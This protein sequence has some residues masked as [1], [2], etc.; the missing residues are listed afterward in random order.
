MFFQIFYEFQKILQKKYLILFLITICIINLGTFIY[1]QQLNPMFPT[2]AYLKLQTQ[3]NKIPNHQRY[4]YIYEEYQ[5]YHAFQIIENIEQLKKNSQENQNIITLLQNENP[6]I[7]TKYQKLYQENHQTY[8]THSIESEAAFLEKIYNEFYIL[9]QYPMYLQEIQEKANTITQIGIFQKNNDFSQKNIEKTAQDYQ[10]L[11]HVNILYENE[12][13][14]QDALSFPITNLLIMISMFVLA[15]SMV[16]DEKEKK[17]FSIIKMTINGQW[18]LMLFKCV[19][20]MFIVGI[21]MFIMLLSQL[22]YMNMTVGIGHLSKSIQSL[23]S[24]SYCPFAINVWQ[25]LWLFFLMKWIAISF[26]GLLMMWFLIVMKHKILALLI[27][28]ILVGIEFVLYIFIPPL[29][30]LYLLKYLNIVSFLQIQTLFQIYRNINIL[31]EAV[32][33]QWLMF[34][35][36]MIGFIFIFIMCI[37]TYHYKK[38]MLVSIFEFPFSFKRHKISSSLLVQ[39]FYKTF[40]IQ[41]ALVLCVVCIGLQIYQYHDIT[42][43]RNQEEIIYMEYMKKLEGKL[44]PEKEQ[45]ILQQKQYYES[46]HQQQELIMQKKENKEI[47]SQKANQ[48][49]D[50]INQNLEGE[51]IFDNVLE[52]YQRVTHNSNCEF[53]V[54]YAYQNVFLQNTWTLIPTIVLCIFIIISGSQMFPYEYQNM[55]NRITFITVKGRRKVICNKFIVSFVLNVLFI[56]LTMLPIFLLF[57]QTYGFHSIQASI[58]SIEQFS[59]FPSFISIGMGCFINI[60][61]KLFAVMCMITMIHVIALKTR[62]N[63]LTC[64]IASLLFLMPLLLVFGNYHILDAISL[65]PLFMNGIYAI[66]ESGL[67]Q[68]LYSLIGYLILMIFSIKYIYKNYKA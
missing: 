28:I 39:E 50:M 26:I 6:D 13:G 17:L 14:I 2:S 16:I 18:K 48:T 30:I 22:F 59:H 32:S 21:L 55:M 36:L 60:L 53:I 19:V 63:I 43:Y 15:S 12:K 51:R 68:L 49:L 58:I 37:L 38:N 64:F 57:H 54:P 45:W 9:Y 23:A 47:T 27:I 20:F 7:Q 35:V 3:L 66:E 29:H 42:I 25:F 8:Y 65:Y 52:Q 24:F 1:D 62:N 11:Y 5:K 31:G 40:W 46:L 33:L 61:L 41:K 56:I 10:N 44:T 4:Q 67:T 34:I